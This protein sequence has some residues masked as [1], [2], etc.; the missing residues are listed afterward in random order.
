MTILPLLALIAIGQS[1][2][3]DSTESILEAAACDPDAFSTCATGP[4]RIFLRK[5]GNLA[6]TS[7]IPGAKPIHFLLHVV[8]HVNPET[9]QSGP[10]V[11]ADAFK[12]GKGKRRGHH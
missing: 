12:K 4:I 3:A 9:T 1:P 5:D 7:T 10:V 8:P 6:L 11:P 2:M